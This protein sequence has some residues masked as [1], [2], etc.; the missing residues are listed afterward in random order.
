[1]SYLRL[2]IDFGQ[3][4]AI[5]VLRAGERSKGLK[6]VALHI[7]DHLGR[8]V[9]EKTVYDFCRTTIDHFRPDLADCTINGYDFD[10]REISHKFFVAHPSLP[11]V[12]RGAPLEYIEIGA[13]S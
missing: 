3:N 7:A 9:D 13:E 10:M 6:S 2:P 4:M 8:H 12:M 5:L 11:R 1:M